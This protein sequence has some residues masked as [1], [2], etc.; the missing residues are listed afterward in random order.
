MDEFIYARRSTVRG[1]GRG[2][3]HDV[4]A[5]ETWA[6]EAGP[7]GPEEQQ[8]ASR[9]RKNDLEGDDTEDRVEYRPRAHCYM[10][11]RT[12]ICDI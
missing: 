10:H 8:R 3:S 2:G 6:I 12:A 5:F 1:A 11:T 4:N 7:S 9:A